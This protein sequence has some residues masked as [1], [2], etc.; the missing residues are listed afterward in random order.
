MSITVIL[1]FAA[2]AG[3]GIGAG[4]VTVRWLLGKIDAEREARQ[5]SL[6]REHEL[7]DQEVATLHSRINDLRG[8]FVRRDDLMLHIDRIERS[9][10]SLAR[11]NMT[12]HTALSGMVQAVSSRIDQLVDRSMA[13]VKPNG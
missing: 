4:A 1:Q 2:L 13:A 6:R 12:Q 8:E 9:V 3:A 11:E 10:E 7:R 5:Q